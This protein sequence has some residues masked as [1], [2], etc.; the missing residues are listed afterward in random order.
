[1]S[2]VVVTVARTAGDADITASPTTITFTPANWNVPRTVT[3]SAA[4]DADKING[5]ATISVS[6]TG[7]STRTLAATELDDDLFA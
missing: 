1:V 7:M 6:A 2:D 5:S 4:Q 3:L